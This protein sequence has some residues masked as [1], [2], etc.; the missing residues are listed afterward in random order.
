MLILALCTIL[1]HAR[2][3]GVDQTKT[4]VLSDNKDKPIV[5]SAATYIGYILFRRF[6]RVRINPKKLYSNEV[7][8]GVRGI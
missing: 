7:A 4:H 5:A 8:M 1:L 6:I 3:M 2:L